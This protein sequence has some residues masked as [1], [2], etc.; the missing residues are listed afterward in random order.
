MKDNQEVSSVMINQNI[1]TTVQEGIKTTYR[2][3]DRD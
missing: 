3:T 1:P 2:R